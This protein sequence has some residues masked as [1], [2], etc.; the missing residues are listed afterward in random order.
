MNDRIGNGDTLVAALQDLIRE[1]TAELT[2][3]MRL[4]KDPKSGPT[5][6]LIHSNR[7]EATKAW[8]TRLAGIVG[9]AQMFLRPID[10]E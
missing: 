10:E 8:L 6:W 7:A 2:E 5:E 3:E 9:S 4:A 1:M